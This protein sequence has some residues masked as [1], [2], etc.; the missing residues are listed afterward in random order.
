[1]QQGSIHSILILCPAAVGGAAEHVYYQAR[2]L[3]EL[4]VNVSILCP[5]NYLENRP[6]DVPTVRRLLPGDIKGRGSG[7]PGFA[8]LQRLRNALVFFARVVV[9]FWVLA[10]VVAVRRPDAVLV[11]SF[12]E[13]FSPFW[14]WPHLLLSRLRGVIYAANLQDP[15]RSWRLGPKWWHELSV[16]LAFAPLSVALI[17][18]LLPDRSIVPGHVVLVQVPVGVYELKSAQVD[19]EAVRRGWAAGKDQVAFLAFGFIRDNKNLDLLIRA[20]AQVPTA[21]LAVVGRCQSSTNKPLQYYRDLAV[22]CGVAGRV[23]FSEEFVPDESLAGYFSAADVIAITY[24]KH[25]HSQ[26]G[27]LNVAARCRKLVL[28][29]S[30]DGPLKSAVINFRLG[31]FVK[32]DDLASTAEGMRHLCDDLIQRR[33][34][35][36]GVGNPRQQ[37][38]QPDYQGY[39]DYASWRTNAEI[40]MQTLSGARAASAKS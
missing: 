11:A 17:H 20:L 3:Q 15:V 38:E 21:F 25:F 10:W 13:Y 19:S 39:E 24:N 22:S 23:H 33:V 5:P 37:N 27:V 32:P 36:R 26:S 4:G 2:A 1:M 9:A 40:L 7:T 14:V 16:R 12:M 8:G 30:G 28:A 34:L 18:E 6:L 31:M 29:S 35:E